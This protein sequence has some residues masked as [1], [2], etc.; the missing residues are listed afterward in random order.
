[1]HR[2]YIADIERGGRNITLRSI[3]SIAKALD[4]PVGSLF[5]EAAG[6][7]GDTAASERRKAG[8]ILVVDPAGADAEFT[9]RS[10][11]QAKVTNHVKVVRDGETALAHL[12]GADHEERRKASHL[13]QLVMLALNLPKMSAVEV[14]RQ[15][16]NDV[17]TRAIPVVI[18]ATSRHDRALAECARLGA[19]NFI[20]KPVDFDSLTRLTP[21]LDLEWTLSLPSA[22]G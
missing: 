19:E 7:A 18:L 16:R 22:A 10:L 21:K 20:L 2:T 9:R 12:L 15:M 6:A 17:R 11:K 14:L 4:V 5:V 13:P 1:M 3:L 8:E